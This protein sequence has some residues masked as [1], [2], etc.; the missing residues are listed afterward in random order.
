MRTLLTVE[1]VSKLIAGGRPLL[2]A[3]TE[4]LLRRLPRGCWLGGTIPYFM[5]EEGG[6][7]S[8]ERLLATTLPPEC[9]SATVKLYADAELASI[10][11]DYPAQGVSF[12]VLPAGS[13]ATARYA[14]ESASWPGFFERPLVGWV[15]GVS[16]DRLATERAKVIDGSTGDVRDD[17]AGVLHVTLAPGVVAKTEI[18]NLFEA[19]DGEVITFPTEG[20]SAQQCT[21]NGR[22]YDFAT[23]LTERKVDVRWPLVADFSGANIN[24]AFQSVDVAAGRV[25]F[26]APV[27]RGVEYR[28]ARPVTDYVDRFARVLGRR[29]VTPIFSCNCILNYLYAELE[30]KKT[31]DVVGPITFGEVAWM[32]LN[33][34]MVYV[35]L[36]RVG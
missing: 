32:L 5:T 10:P 4:A 27:F 21:V 11:R 1:D 12:I 15:A 35:T 31:G 26:Y 14:R 33:Q 8:E 22:P 16:L 36:E 13:S 17:A 6:Q 25:A 18:I 19:G 20:F 23:W 29:G 3:G 2:V 7:H 28:L 9:V 24:V 34:T 30:G